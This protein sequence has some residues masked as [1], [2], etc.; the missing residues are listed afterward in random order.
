MALGYQVTQ[1]LYVAARL[2]LADHLGEK[3]R[4]ASEV[5][6]A[7]GTD[8]PTL[9][10]LMRTLTGLDILS[11]DAD[12]RFVLTSLGQALKTDAL[13]N[14]R[15]M[16]VARADELMWRS[17]GELLHCVKTGE[18]G[19]E[20]AFGMTVWDYYAQNPEAWSSFNKSQ[21]RP[22]TKAAIAEAYDFSQFETV[23]DVGGGSGA[24]LAAILER[25]P[26]PNG[27]LFD[28]PN[29]VADASLFLQKRGLEARTTLDPGDFFRGVSSGGDA[30][31]LSHVLHD[32][33]DEHCLT[34]LENCRKAINAEGKLLIIE[35][36]VPSGNDP[37]PSKMLD[38]EMLVIAGGQERTQQEYSRLLAKA[39]FLLK[40]VMPTSVAQSIVEATPV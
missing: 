20:K 32:W 16:I 18:T 8:A 21:T 11:E 25:Y 5:A 19:V 17:W 9:Y 38:M 34:I 36:V 39:G 12:H 33:N 37:H 30:Y 1:V 2:G 14:A 23:V 35:L 26:G 13:G 24:L 4:S 3:P 31:L 29:V 27:V 28:Q 7:M 22:G 15:T 6:T 10:R 40:R